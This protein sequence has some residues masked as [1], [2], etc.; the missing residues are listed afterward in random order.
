[1]EDDLRVVRGLE[2]DDAERDLRAWRDEHATYI[3]IRN[4]YM[5]P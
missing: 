2:T 3:S 5:G 4:G 1:M